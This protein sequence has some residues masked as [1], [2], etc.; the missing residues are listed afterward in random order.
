MNLHP[1]E[2][3]FANSCWFFSVLSNGT[4]ERAAPRGGSACCAASLSEHFI[5]DSIQLRAVGRKTLAFVH[6]WRW[7]LHGLP[8]LSCS[9][10]GE[11]V[12]LNVLVNLFKMSLRYRGEKVLRWS[13]QCVPIS[14]RRQWEQSR[15]FSVMLSEKMRQWAQSTGKSI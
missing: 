6:K 4:E 3:S 15:P 1:L 12:K 10:V 2:S 7:G 8:A 11:T 14:Y 13:Y 5:K 9:A